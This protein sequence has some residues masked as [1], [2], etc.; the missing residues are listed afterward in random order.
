M[1]TQIFHNADK[2][3]V[4]VIHE[5]GNMTRYVGTAFKIQD[6]PVG[7]KGHWAVSFPM[8]G[9]SYIFEEKMHLHWGYVMEKLG[10]RMS[11]RPQQKACI[12]EMTK[13]IAMM[14][15]G[16]TVS[17]CTDETGHLNDEEIMRDTRNTP[18]L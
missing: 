18:T 11:G 16:V 12:S 2:T 13:I 8:G 9:G 15:P 17:T 10:M 3:S 14:I 1:P 7:Y 6:G 5:P 4:L